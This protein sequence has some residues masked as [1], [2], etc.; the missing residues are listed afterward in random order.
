MNLAQRSTGTQTYNIDHLAS[1]YITIAPTGSTLPDRSMLR[2]RTKDMGDEDK[3]AMVVVKDGSAYTEYQ[4]K[5]GTVVVPNFEDVD[6]VVV[7]LANASR[8]QDNV[9]FEFEAEVSGGS[10]AYIIDRSGSMRGTPLANAKIAANQGITTMQEGDEVAVV[11]FS[12]SAGVNYSRTT[13]DA[14]A[15]RNAARGGRELS[16]GGWRNVD[17]R[18][19]TWRLQRTERVISSQQG[20]G[21]AVRRIP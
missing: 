20:S 2:I 8:T 14:D 6:E 3:R 15:V 13:I 17:W 18:W 4:A 10:I 9:T 16:V 12:T 7:I 19:T 5:Y 21:T 1:Q 11:S